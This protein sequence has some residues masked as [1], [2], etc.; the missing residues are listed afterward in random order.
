MSSPGRP[1]DEYRSAQHEGSPVSRAR[2][3]CSWYDGAAID[4]AAA[5]RAVQWL[6]ALHEAPDCQ[7]LRQ[8]LQRWRDEHPG[9]ER[10]WRRIE[11]VQGRLQALASPPGARFAQAAL[12]SDRRG[13][14]RGAVKALG[15]LALAGGAAWQASRLAPWREWSAD[16]RTA[17]GQTQALSLPDGSRLA[18]NTASAIDVRYTEAERRIVLI[19]GEIL[20]ATAQENRPAYRP[21]LV[22]TAQGTALAL[23]TEYAVRQQDE[24]TLVNV[25]AGAVRIQPRRNAGRTLVLHAGQGARYTAHAVM[26]PG[27]AD[28]DSI[29]WQEGFIVARGMRLDALLAELGR[30]TGLALSCDPALAGLRVSGSYPV[31]APRKV[32]SVLAAT[33]QLRLQAQAGT[34]FWRRGRLHLLPGTRQG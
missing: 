26:A 19:A 15:G 14:R 20:V 9:H 33:L 7:A 2:H 30:Y 4:P 23:G 1:K 18:M 24:D 12:A 28:A 21:F 25:F 5:D 8:G 29:A 22:E 6:L 13:A 17:V 10:A 31:D 3:A 11:A 27:P 32:M 34:A 16:Y